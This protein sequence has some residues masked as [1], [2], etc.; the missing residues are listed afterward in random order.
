[1]HHHSFRRSACP[2]RRQLSSRHTAPATHQ[3]YVG[4]NEYRH[5]TQASRCRRRRLMTLH[6]HSHPPA[7][8]EAAVDRVG[9]THFRST[10]SRPCRRSCATAWRN[11]CDLSHASDSHTGSAPRQ[12]QYCLAIGDQTPLPPIPSRVDRYDCTH[13][14]PTTPRSPSSPLVVARTDR[15]CTSQYGIGCGSDGLSRCR[16]VERTNTVARQDPRRQFFPTRHGIERRCSSPPSAATIAIDADR[17]NADAVTI[18]HYRRFHQPESRTRAA[19]YERTHHRRRVI[20]LSLQHSFTSTSA[21][22]GVSSAVSRTPTFHCARHTSPAL[23]TRS[24]AYSRSFSQQRQVTRAS[25]FCRA[26]TPCD[27]VASQ[28]STRHRN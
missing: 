28:R 17:W 3:P 13:E 9:L 14:Q 21:S 27:P 26:Q 8:Y 19:K 2:L 22:G 25:G 24:P 18:S 6:T 20:P 4:G 5:P 7:R 16:H 1:M 15:C 11:S 23:R 10:G 12:H